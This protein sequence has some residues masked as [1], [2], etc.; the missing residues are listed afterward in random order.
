MA[1]VIV[2]ISVRCKLTYYTW[3]LGQ[4]SCIDQFSPPHCW[5]TFSNL[6]PLLWHHCIST[7]DSVIRYWTILSCILAYTKW[8]LYCIVLQPALENSITTYYEQL[9]AA[10]YTVSLP[11]YSRHCSLVFG[12]V[13]RRKPPS[14]EWCLTSCLPSTV[15]TSRRWCY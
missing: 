14:C 15:A 12:P 6:T 10:L 8:L 2:M 9:V 13:I 4:L 7:T 3:S 1:F 11:A 5:H